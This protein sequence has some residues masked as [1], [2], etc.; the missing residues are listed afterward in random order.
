MIDEEQFRELMTELAVYGHADAPEEIDL[1]L[2]IVDPGNNQKLTYSQVVKLLSQQ[3]I[4]IDHDGLY[5][6]Q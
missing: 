6:L 2:E 4:D 5:G 3:T 1:L